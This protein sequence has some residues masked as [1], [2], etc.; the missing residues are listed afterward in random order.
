MTAR[1][2]LVAT[3]LFVLLIAGPVCAQAIND[4]HSVKM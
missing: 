1:L 4:L 2:I 3:I